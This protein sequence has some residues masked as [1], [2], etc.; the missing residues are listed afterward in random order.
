MLCYCSLIKCFLDV[1]RDENISNMVLHEKHGLNAI[2]SDADP[3]S[4]EY[5]LGS[6]K[7]RNRR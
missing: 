4:N 7:T 5:K 2:V 1:T 3:D 6:K